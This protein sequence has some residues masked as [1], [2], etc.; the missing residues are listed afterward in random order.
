MVMK[1]NSDGVQENCVLCDRVWGVIGLGLGAFILFIGL[2]LVTNGGISHRIGTL[3]TP[4]LSSVDNIG[5][6]DVE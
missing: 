1:T 5:D 2:D 4:L 3:A 6:N